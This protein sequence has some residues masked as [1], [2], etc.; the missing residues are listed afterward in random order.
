[1]K[2]LVHPGYYLAQETGEVPGNPMAV[3]LVDGSHDDVQGV[4]DAKALHERIFPGN[5]PY[6]MVHVTAVPAG[7]PKINEEAADLCADL[8]AGRLGPTS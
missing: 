3:K 7:E 8:M 1:M 2:P 4:I 6:L 5:G